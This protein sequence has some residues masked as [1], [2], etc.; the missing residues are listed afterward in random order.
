MSHAPTGNGTIRVRQARE[1]DI[2]AIVKLQTRLLG[3]S[4]VTQ[5]GEAFLR[6]FYAAAFQDSNSVAFVAVHEDSINGFAIGTSDV[7]GFHRT[8]MPRIAIAM[9]VALIAP[10]RLHLL[11][12]FMH[13]LFEKEAEPHIDAELVFLFVDSGHQRQRIGSRL[14]ASLEEW[15]RQRAC[16]R[17]RVAVRSQLVAA[18]SFYEAAGFTFEQQ[19]NVLGD[20]MTYLVRRL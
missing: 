9:V 5:L 8:M 2:P 3:D 4:L 6:R 19:V 10:R 17:Y 13:R 7:T 20:P 1:E 14:V 18:I 16:S 11:S 12:R 15:L